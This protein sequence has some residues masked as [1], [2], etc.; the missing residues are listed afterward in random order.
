[1]KKSLLNQVKLLG[2]DAYQSPNNQWVIELSIDRKKLLLQEQES[3]QWLLICNENPQM[4]LK[5]RQILTYLE[6]IQ[7]NKAI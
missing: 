6:K 7:E 2:C 1:M 4:F 3:N 5:T